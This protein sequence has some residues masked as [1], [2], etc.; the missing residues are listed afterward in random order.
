MPTSRESDRPC[1]R[2]KAN[3]F[4]TLAGFFPAVVCKECDYCAMILMT[5]GGDNVPSL[6]P[7]PDGTIKAG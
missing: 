1:P 4:V 5:D 7:E 6:H 2:C 3:L